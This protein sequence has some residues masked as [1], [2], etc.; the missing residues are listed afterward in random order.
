MALALALTSI[1][2]LVLGLGLGLEGQVLGLGLGLGYH[3]LG[4]GLG[5][6]NLALTTS[7]L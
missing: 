2:G 7:L 3:V 4:L 1:E 6:V 5:L